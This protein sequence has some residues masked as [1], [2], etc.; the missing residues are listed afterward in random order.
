MRIR[1]VNESIDKNDILSVFDDIIEEFD[2]NVGIVDKV[3]KGWQ[4]EQISVCVHVKFG[5]DGEDDEGYY[6]DIVG[7]SDNNN[8]REL[9]C[10][11]DHIKLLTMMIVAI[12][13][14]RL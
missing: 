5:N 10:D 3:V 8:E 9:P 7:F 1:R 13:K 14:L 12:K 4:K 6:Y 11:D 2:A